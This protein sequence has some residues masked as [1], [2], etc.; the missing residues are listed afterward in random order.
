MKQENLANIRHKLS[1]IYKHIQSMH[2][3][4]RYQEK[5]HTISKKLSKGKKIKNKKQNF[6]SSP[7]FYLFIY[8]YVEKIRQK[9]NKD[10]L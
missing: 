9:N 1:F 4:Q 6:A 2:N 3:E 7:P 5:I 10:V 8:F